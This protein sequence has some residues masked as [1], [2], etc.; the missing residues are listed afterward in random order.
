VCVL[1]AAVKELNYEN[2]YILALHIDTSVND[3][4]ECRI[5]I[6]EDLSK[7][8]QNGRLEREMQMVQL[9]ATRCSCIAIL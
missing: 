9:S 7:S 1:L 3:N 8:S 4:I 6:H 5:M 2:K